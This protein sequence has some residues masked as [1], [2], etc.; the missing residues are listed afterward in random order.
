[1]IAKLFLCFSMKKAKVSCQ[2]IAVSKDLGTNVAFVRILATQS[3]VA[4]SSEFIL[5]ISD[6][7]WYYFSFSWLNLFQTHNWIWNTFQWYKRLERIRW[8]SILST[9]I[10]AF[11]R[12]I[13]SAGV[14]RLFRPL[15]FCIRLRSTIG[16]EKLT[17]LIKHTLTLSQRLNS[18]FK[19]FPQKFDA[20]SA[21][22]S[23]LRSI[24]KIFFFNLDIRLQVTKISRHCFQDGLHFWQV[25][26]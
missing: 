20:S 1:M 13:S 2:S 22:T 4:F 8:I 23:I 14:H 18:H 6:H 12:K 26:E 11:F 10:F 9:N 17:G 7:N 3:N 24:L 15:C 5:D 21:K 19:L 16:S 25:Y